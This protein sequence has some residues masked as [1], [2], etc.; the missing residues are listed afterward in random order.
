ML[1]ADDPLLFQHV[2]DRGSSWSWNK[3]KSNDTKLFLLICKSSSFGYQRLATLCTFSLWINTLMGLQQ[4]IRFTLQPNG[5]GKI[6]HWGKVFKKL[7]RKNILMLSPCRSRFLRRRNFR[8]AATTAAVTA[9]TCTR[10]SAAAT[11]S[12]WRAAC[13]WSTKG[14][15]TKVSSTS[16]AP[17]STLTASS[18][19]PSATASNPAVLWRTWEFGCKGFRKHLS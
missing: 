2:F 18:G 16:S 4:R 12:G 6:F 7:H 14:P 1:F 15:A 9:P 19:W 11:P 17:G 3:G 13:G 10:I 8:A 5:E